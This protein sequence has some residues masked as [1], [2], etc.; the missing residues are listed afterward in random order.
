MKTL[1]NKCSYCKFQIAEEDIEMD[2]ATTTYHRGCRASADEFTDNVPGQLADIIRRTKRHCER[3][4]TLYALGSDVEAMRFLLDLYE[5][6]SGICPL[7]GMEMD[8]S[9][10]HEYGFLLKPSLDRV[11]SSRGYEQG[12]LRFLVQWANLRRS[13]LTD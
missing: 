6:Q 8:C 13:F 7:T 12:N 9:T 2:N 11:D 1:T 5:S 10:D 3:D 4:G